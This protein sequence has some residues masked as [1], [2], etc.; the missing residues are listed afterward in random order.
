MLLLQLIDGAHAVRIDL[1]RALGSTLSRAVRVDTEAGELDVVS[2]E[3][4]VARTTAL[5]Y[6]GPR[7]GQRIDVKHALAFRRLLGL[8]RREQLP[9]VWNHHRQDVARTLEEG[10]RER[11]RSC[12]MRIQSW[13]SERNTP[14]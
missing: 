7:R 9:A 4:L 2:V 13:W 8:G 3:D 11:P 6:G 1:L 14:G 12:S 10:S 5:V